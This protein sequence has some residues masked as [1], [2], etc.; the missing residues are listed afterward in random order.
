[1]TSAGIAQTISSKMTGESPIRPVESAR[2]GS[3]EPPGET[4][5]RDDHRDDNRE[6]DYRGIDQDQLLSL[7]D[8][9]LRIEDAVTPCQRQRK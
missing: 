5:R 3:A 2:I 6:H 4:R 7:A 1:M 9:P 8:W